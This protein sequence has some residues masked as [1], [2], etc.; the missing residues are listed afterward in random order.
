MHSLV[1][2]VVVPVTKHA[3]SLTV[4]MAQLIQTGCLRVL[5]EAAASTKGGRGGALGQ[6][7]PKGALMALAVPALVYRSPA[8]PQLKPLRQGMHKEGFRGSSVGRREVALLQAISRDLCTTLYWGQVYIQAESGPVQ[9]N[10]EPDS[11]QCMLLDVMKSCHC[12]MT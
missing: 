4:T 1:A 11:M 12:Y 9:H 7:L 8:L 5:T 10:S 3:R 2:L 6:Q